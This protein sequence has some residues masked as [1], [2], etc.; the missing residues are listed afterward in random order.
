MR[1]RGYVIICEDTDPPAYVRSTLFN[2][3]ENFSFAPTEAA[4]WFRLD[5]CYAVRRS[6]QR[7][8]SCRLRVV[9]V[10]VHPD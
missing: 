6:F 2:D 3:H 7:R 1:R 8:E 10:Y 5:D 4:V 9:P